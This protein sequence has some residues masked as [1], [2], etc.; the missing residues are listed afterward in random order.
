MKG[1][2]AGWS[3]CLFLLLIQVLCFSACDLPPVS[4]DQI[5][6]A[7]KNVVDWMDKAKASSQELADSIG[8]ANKDLAQY[9]NANNLSNE[10]IKKMENT[11]SSLKGKV[12]RLRNCANNIKS[13]SVLL[14]SLLKK[15]TEENKTPQLK[16]RMSQNISLH[17]AE[18]ERVYQVLLDM[19]KGYDGSIQKYDDL[20]GYVQVNRGLVGIDQ[21]IVELNNC[22]REA[23]SL[24]REISSAM[25]E[26]QQIV[27]SIQ[28][29]EDAR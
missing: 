2:K 8:K 6:R 12:D 25:N 10:T 5:S 7:S 14:F 23:V 15:R 13:N 28:A 20:L 19:V 3:I 22:I 9:L 16:E 11:K 21:M 17:E 26:G 29:V 18:L 4:I 27:R 24:N 1:I